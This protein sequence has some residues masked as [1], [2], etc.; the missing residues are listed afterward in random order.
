MTTPRYTSEPPTEAG[1]LTVRCLPK[2]CGTAAFV[3]LNREMIEE[4]RRQF[5]GPIPRP[6]E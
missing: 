1:E 3:K 4:V 2:P 6:E 5:A